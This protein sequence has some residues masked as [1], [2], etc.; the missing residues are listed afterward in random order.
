MDELRTSVIPTIGNIP[1]SWTVTRVDLV[2][3]VRTGLQRSAERQTGRYATKYLRS[4][5]ITANG[6]DLDDVREMDFTPEERVTFGLLPGDILLNEASGSSGRVGRAA[7]WR[8]EIEGC[9]YQNHLIRFRPHAVVPEYA[10]IVFQNHAAAGVFARTARGVGIQHLGASRFAALP[11]PLPPLAEQRRIAEATSEKLG[12]IREA[13]DRLHSA[14]KNLSAQTREIVAAATS[15][16]LL[17]APGEEGSNEMSSAQTHCPK[18]EETPGIQTVEPLRFNSIPINWTWTTIGD[19]GEAKLGRQRSPAHHHGPNMRPY[20]RV[21]NVL[22]DR[23]E[24]SDLLRMNFEPQEAAEYELRSGDIL[25]NEGQ[26]P[27]LVGRAALYRGEV[28][29]ACFQ[30]TLIRF[31]ARMN[32][33]PAFAL[34]VF[35]Q[36]LYSGIFREAA[37]WSTNIAHLGLR[38][39]CALPFPLP[40]LDD[41]KRIAEEARRRL[42]A[43]ED[44]AS[45][46]RVSLVN[47]VD[48]ERDLL[49]AAVT[50]ELALQDPNDEAADALLSRLGPPPV[51]PKVRGRSRG[52]TKQMASKSKPVR[53]LTDQ[54]VDLAAVLRESGGSLSLPE[55]FRRAGFDRDQ[56]EHVERF[57][58]VLRSQL[59]VSI[60][61]TRGNAENAVVE[62]SDAD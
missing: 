59:G 3:T 61:L 21:A 4:A 14:M 30:N 6:L 40:L 47:V 42:E 55:L 50:G 10:L 45:A 43:T 8:G 57:Y 5:N 12:Q 41:Q 48:M 16:T 26:S 29:G 62:A 19:V 13:A 32:V 25:L 38:R 18:P 1:D 54:I 52:D 31:R 44:Q 37:R 53:R 49:A 34:L 46:V 22:E 39:F 51:T 28:P 17:H 60:R 24:T 58:L 9:C 35:R 15:G 11:F 56:T 36:Y 7:I 2:G 20:L 23:I 33:E 27:E